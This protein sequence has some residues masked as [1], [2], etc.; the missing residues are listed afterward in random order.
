MAR[1]RRL[2]SDYG[3]GFDA[4][5]LVRGVFHGTGP[6]TMRMRAFLG[7]PWFMAFWGAGVLR[8]DWFATTLIQVRW[9]AR[10]KYEDKV[11]AV[12][13]LEEAMKR[14][15][16]AVDARWLALSVSIPARAGRPW[17]AEQWLDDFLDKDSGTA[18]VV[19]VASVNTVVKG[20]VSTGKVEE[21]RRVANRF[22]NH[23]NPELR[24]NVKTFSIIVDGCAKRR[25]PESTRR[26]LDR[27]VQ[28]GI[29][30][31]TVTYNG[32]MEAAC[33]SMPVKSAGPILAEM[34]DR[35]LDPDNVTYNIIVRNLSQAGR[36]PEARRVLDSM[37]ASRVTPDHVSF[38]T[39]LDGY[40]DR[41]LVS[42]V[43]S[44]LHDMKGQGVSMDAYSAARFLDFEAKQNAPDKAMEIFRSFNQQGISMDQRSYHSIIYVLAKNERDKE[45]QE[46]LRRFEWDEK[47]ESLV[48]YRIL[49]REYARRRRPDLQKWLL[50]HLRMLGWDIDAD[51]LRWVWASLGVHRPSRHARLVQEF[52]LECGLEFRRDSLCVPAFFAAGFLEDPVPAL[53]VV[54]QH[55]SDDIT[56]QAEI[57]LLAV[58]L[59]HTKG[60]TDPSDSFASFLRTACRDELR[61]RSIQVTRL[62]QHLE[63]C[64]PSRERECLFAL[65]EG[66]DH[67]AA[68]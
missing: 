22:L 10:W 51:M 59:R 36:L 6:D 45:A 18:D 66:Q 17:E 30:P 44:V 28:L 40:L 57:C 47:F 55:F 64:S 67:R 68:A 49:S 23:P 56:F 33:A 25:D 3:Q 60:T 65:L 16:V 63:E 61:T 38:N 39:I 41:N 2:S 11:A 52:L 37:R 43:G 27:M 62:R 42:E 35:N 8:R 13:V 24:S 21:A 14:L 31:N 20:Y 19:N 58:S 4:R 50:H 32:L 9:N 46:V 53:R 54:K 1:L 5:D 34:K 12:R 7:G 15:H 29:A 26:E 48:P